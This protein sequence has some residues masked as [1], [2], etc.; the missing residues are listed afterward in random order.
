MKTTDAIN[1]YGSGVA[2][3]AVL[4]LSSGAVSHWGEYPPDARQVQLERITFGAI[5]AEPGCL[6]RVLG[7]DKVQ[8]A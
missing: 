3:T 8:V 1:Y 4:G 2:L 5:R 7:M 6:D